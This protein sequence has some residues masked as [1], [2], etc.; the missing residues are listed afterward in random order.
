MVSI[1]IYH[2][3]WHGDDVTG[4]KPYQCTWEGCTWRFARSDELT[5]HF[6]KHTGIKPFRCTD[7]DRSFSRSDHLALHRRR[8]VMMWNSLCPSLPSP[9]LPACS[10][11][12]THAHPGVP[13]AVDVTSPSL[14]M[15]TYV[16]NKEVQ[17][18]ARPYWLPLLVRTWLQFSAMLPEATNHPS[19]DDLHLHLNA[20][21]LAVTWRDY[22]KGKLH[23][24]LL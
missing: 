15:W 17:G 21:S 22:K 23:A 6:R 9:H 8:H 19:T 7:C 10:S 13:N 3:D 24:A 4:E 11:G 5:R 16:L 20:W 1:S 12:D 18:V 2:V 14:Q